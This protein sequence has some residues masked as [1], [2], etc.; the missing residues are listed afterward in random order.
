MIGGLVGKIKKDLMLFSIAHLDDEYARWDP[1]YIQIEATSKC[2]LHCPGCS[3]SREAMSGQHLSMDQLQRILDLLPFSPKKV[4]LSGVG[5]PLL[6][7]QFFS[8]VDLLAERRTS[9]HFFT[10]GTLLSQQASEAIVARKN[11]ASLTVSCDGAQEATFEN[12]RLGAHFESWQ[13]SVHYLA[14]K[15]KDERPGLRIGMNTVISKQNLDELEDI[16]R[17]AAGLGVRN[18]HFL[19]PIPVDEITA[20]QVPSESEFARIDFDELSELGRSLG[21]GVSW[22]IRRGGKYPARVQ[23]CLHPWNTIF[24]RT[25]GNVQPC[26]ALFGTDKAAVMGNIF[27]DTFMDIWNGHHYREYRRG[28]RL[29]TNALCRVCPYN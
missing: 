6:N 12:L 15:A 23:R 11:I 22:L 26:M 28:N 14:E 3:H 10:N 2:N 16:V 19:D 24:V 9:C 8:M 27:Q 4:I 18:V 21:L 1:T 25:N 13:R 29:K 7:P 17:M 5:E 20:A